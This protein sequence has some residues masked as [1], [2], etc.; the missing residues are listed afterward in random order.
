MYSVGR[1][2]AR[3]PRELLHESNCA[4]HSAPRIARSDG[5]MWMNSRTGPAGHPVWIGGTNLLPYRQ[6]QR[7]L[8][9]ATLSARM[10]GRGAR[11]LRGRAGGGRL[12]DVR[13]RAAGCAPALPRVELVGLA[14][15]LAEHAR[16][17]ATPMSD[18]RGRA[19]RDLEPLVC[20]LD[21]LDTLSHVSA[22]DVVLQQLDNAHETELLAISKDLWRPRSGL[23]N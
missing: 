1:L 16:P 7:A 21:L 14:M 12:A 15:P 20:L 18:K 13:T 23:K 9:A 2:R 5:M 6:S 10:V 11:R 22:D 17:S 8:R 3:C 19:S 4:W